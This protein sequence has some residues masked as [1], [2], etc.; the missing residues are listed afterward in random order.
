MKVVTW[1]VN[2]IRSRHAE[3][4][5][6]AAE[7]K[8]DVLCLQEIKAAPSQVPEPLTT[9][10]EYW[11]Y[12]HGRVGGYS[13]VSLHLLRA[14]FPQA[15]AFA[16]PHFDVETRMVEVEL[17]ECVYA[18]VYVPNGGK[19]YAAKL[20]FLRQLALWAP[21]HHA[22]GKRVMLCGDLNVTHTPADVH[23]TQRDE[24]ALCQRPEERVLFE[25]LLESGLVDVGRALAPSDERYFTWWPA[26]RDA[27]ARNF[28][29]RLD[30]LLASRELA[31]R[32]S[33]M[34]V[35]REFGTSDHA[36]LIV[37]MGD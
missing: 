2:G 23:P 37:E 24:R 26:W 13:G 10:S 16:H 15:P 7:A 20:E 36:P 19:D 35:Q 29:W 21:A 12:W 3:V 9:L 34:R 25:R 27:R 6:F 4:V 8:P 5:R 11:S 28:G 1:N 33:A 22:R 30:Y 14:R 18:S 31:E 17:G 32:A